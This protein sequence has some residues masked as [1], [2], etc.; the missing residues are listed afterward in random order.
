MNEPLQKPEKK[1]EKVKKRLDKLKKLM[2]NKDIKNKE[3]E[4]RTHQTKKGKQNDEQR[5]LHRS[6]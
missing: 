5:I 3:I 2:Y 6:Y 4:S 1:F